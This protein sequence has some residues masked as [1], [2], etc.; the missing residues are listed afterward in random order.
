MGGGTQASDWASGAYLEKLKQGAKTHDYVWIVL[1][2]N[3]ALDVMPACAQQKKSV[4]ECGNELFTRALK[5]MTTI[6]EAIHEAN[7][8]AIVVGFGYD[9]MFGGLGCG[10][11]THELMPQC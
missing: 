1:M 3:D 6:V 7:P 11:V 8:A 9:T 4:E 2:G 5:D 10:L